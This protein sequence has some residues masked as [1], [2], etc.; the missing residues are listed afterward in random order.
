MLQ[1]LLDISVCAVYEGGT[2]EA[3]REISALIYP[4][5][6]RPQLNSGGLTVAARGDYLAEGW[7][8]PGLASAPLTSS[9]LPSRSMSQFMYLIV[10][11][12]DLS[13]L[14]GQWGIP[15][16][17]GRLGSSPSCA[18]LDELQVCSTWSSL[19]G[20]S[21]KRVGGWGV[22]GQMRES[23]NSARYRQ[24]IAHLI[25]SGVIKIGRA[26]G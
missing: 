7:R 9:Y 8:E 23:H 3:L 1:T 19:P 11:H 6:F 26:N 17:T 20:L 5:L 24:L 4:S 14:T 15:Q 13:K 12:G 18:S 2:G 22:S 10:K 21:G 25:K 16:E